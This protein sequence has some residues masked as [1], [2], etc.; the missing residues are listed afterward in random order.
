M[1]LA[2]CSKNLG[3][4][5]GYFLFMPV[6]I[7]KILMIIIIWILVFLRTV[8]LSISTCNHGN[9]FPSGLLI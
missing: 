4:D 7:G 2:G 3:P 8:K 5:F 9:Q 6:C 1:C